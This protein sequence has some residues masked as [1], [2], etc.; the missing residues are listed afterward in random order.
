MMMTMASETND[1]SN[2]TRG[3]LSSRTYSRRASSSASIFPLQLIHE[4]EDEEGDKEVPF[5]DYINIDDDWDGTIL[6]S[7]CF[8]N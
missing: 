8:T 6:F 3:G 7:I 1:S 2:P 4:E 5:D